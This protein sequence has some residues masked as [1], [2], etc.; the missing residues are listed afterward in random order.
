MNSKPASISILVLTYN[1]EKNL[2]YLL[3]S[4]KGWVNEICIV[5]S[6]STDRTVEIALAYGAQV[7]VNPFRTYADQFNWGL[8][9][10]EFKS[11]W[12]MRIDADELI[13]PELAA[14]LCEKLHTFPPS[15][16]GLYVKRRVFFMG[17]WI[18][19]GAYYPTWLLRIFRNGKSYCENRWMDE[20]M[21]LTEGTAERL[22]HDIIDENH[23]GLRFF[24]L[25]HEGYAERE[26]MDLLNL[27]PQEKAGEIQGSILGQQ[28]K[29]KRWLK[30]N[31]YS[32][33]PLFWRALFYFLYRFVFRFGFL[34][35]REGLIFHVLQG[36]WYRFYVDAKI[37]ERE[38]Q[39]RST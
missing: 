16:T 23:N 20:H 15:V 7:K 38:Q 1:E 32:R 30:G 37:V 22:E 11:D 4:V 6:G 25:K 31:V 26:M 14:E 8:E 36:F 24:T 12:V 19:H 5:D 27:R 9:H 17:R 29:Q 21:I 3:E 39:T 28:D 35:G 33:A 2:P 13:M 10:F 18:R 34:D